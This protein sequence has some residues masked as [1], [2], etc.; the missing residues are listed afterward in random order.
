MV[1]DKLEIGQAAPCLADN[2]RSD[3]S[4]VPRHTRCEIEPRELVLVRFEGTGTGWA[5]NRH[6]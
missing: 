3:T 4:P 6:S 5:S 2:S 1:V